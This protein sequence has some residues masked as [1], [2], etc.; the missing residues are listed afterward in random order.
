MTQDLVPAGR[1]SLLLRLLLLPSSSLDL[2]Q[3]S[4]KVGFGWIRLPKPGGFDNV[5]MQP[6][7]TLYAKHVERQQTEQGWFY[8]D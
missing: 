2:K 4:R 8:I 6:A 5:F 3:A 1:E 7:N